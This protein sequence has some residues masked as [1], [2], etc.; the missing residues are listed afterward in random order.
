MTSVERKGVT[1]LRKTWNAVMVDHIG[2][3]IVSCPSLVAVGI[4]FDLPE[5]R[6]RRVGISE[7]MFP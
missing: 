2:A 7:G 4:R 6:E 5:G 1:K 3:E